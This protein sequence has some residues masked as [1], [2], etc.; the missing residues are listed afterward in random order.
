M[1]LALVFVLSVSPF[2]VAAHPRGAGCSRRPALINMTM[3]DLA[4]A[5]GVIA[6]A[7]ALVQG[8]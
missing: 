4:S 6:V 3:Y 7:A 1:A 8:K 5:V 2:H